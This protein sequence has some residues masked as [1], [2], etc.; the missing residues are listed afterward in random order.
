MI[1]STAIVT[2]TVTLSVDVR[3]L[4]GTRWSCKNLW[5]FSP[6]LPGNSMY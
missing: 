3:I 2:V 1:L 5:T 4:G 6:V